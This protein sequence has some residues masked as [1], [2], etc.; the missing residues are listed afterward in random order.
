MAGTAGCRR[1]SL[2]HRPT[3]NRPQVGTVAALIRRAPAT[4]VGSVCRAVA[5]ERVL[6]G[7]AGVGPPGGCPPGQDAGGG[8]FEPPSFG[9]LAPVVVTARRSVPTHRRTHLSSGRAAWTAPQG[10]LW[11]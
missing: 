9:L 2:R 8:L 3:E 10:P 11:G 5:L 1:P 7:G 4:S 6:G